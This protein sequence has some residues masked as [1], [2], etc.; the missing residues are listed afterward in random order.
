VATSNI[1]NELKALALHFESFTRFTIY[2]SSTKNS[3]NNNILL[4]FD[5]L[6]LPQKL[7]IIIETFIFY[8]KNIISL[9]NHYRAH[10]NQLVKKLL[11]NIFIIA[12]K[13]ILCFKL[14]TLRCNYIILQYLCWRFWSC[15]LYFFRAVI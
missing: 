12:N 8:K 7:F 2:R 3:K 4:L 6:L 1:N 5:N 9:L 10:P 14:K 11:Q 15:V 13:S